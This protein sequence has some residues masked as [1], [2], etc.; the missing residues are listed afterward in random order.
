MKLPCEAYFTKK[1]PAFNRRLFGVRS[2]SNT[3]SKIVD[4][5]VARKASS[6][7]SIAFIHGVW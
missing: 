4:Y 3:L 1:P 6:E 7:S 2:E 5:F